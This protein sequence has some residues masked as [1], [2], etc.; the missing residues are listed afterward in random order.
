MARFSPVL[1]EDDPKQ[2]KISP[3]LQSLEE[4]L[5]EFDAHADGAGVEKLCETLRKDALK[6]E[7][8]GVGDLIPINHIRRAA[9]WGR[10]APNGKRKVLLIENAGRMKE[11]ARNS[12]LKLLEEPPATL[13]IV[14]TVQRREAIMPTILSR[15]RPYR[16]LK[17][18]AEKEREVIRRVFRDAEWDVSGV[19]ADPGGL[20]SA[21]LETFLPQSTD[22]LKA[23][24]AYFIASAARAAALEIKKK[25]AGEIPAF[26]SALGSR[27]GPIADSAGFERSLYAK[28]VIKTLLAAS[29][30]FE[31]RS[32]SRFLKTALEL[33]SA[34]AREGV[35]GPQA[36]AYNDIWRKHSAEAETAMNVLNQSPALALEAY[37]FRLTGALANG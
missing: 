10:L 20:I 24:A 5:D 26:V 37:F 33:V 2:G 27:Y 11:E 22:K 21:Y 19:S 6:L 16:F 25:G 29:G 13:N 14:L 7:S 28:D 34:A 36:V 8:E 9:Y 35:S 3:L 12:L 4:G 18:D 30:N 1:L 17:R 32:S 31:G 23:L 15:L